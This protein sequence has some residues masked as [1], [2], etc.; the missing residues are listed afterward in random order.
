MYKT[1]SGVLVILGLVVMG[2]AMTMDVTVDVPGQFNERVFNLHLA[3][4]QTNTLFLGGIA[5]V[6]GIILFVS[7]RRKSDQAVRL[8][9]QQDTTNAQVAPESK[10]R[11]F[12]RDKSKS[13]KMVM[14]GAVFAII[15]TLLNWTNHYLSTL[16]VGGDRISMMSLVVLIGCWSFPLYH[17]FKGLP[18]TRKQLAVTST[19]LVLWMLKEMLFA[20]NFGIVNVSIG[21]GIWMATISGCLLAWAAFTHKNG[22]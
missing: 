9:P 8:T 13:E 15:S 2:F 6:A 7:T 19:I 12:W 22:K 1:V 10:V 18:L 21:M 17:V 5:F 16:K 20:N 3:S 11:K 4:Q 14:V